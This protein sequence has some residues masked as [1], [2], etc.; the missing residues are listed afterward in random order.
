L[1]FRNTKLL[2]ALLSVSVCTV[3]FVMN[4]CYDI[5]VKLFSGHLLLFSIF[6]VLL[7]Y[8]KLLL[9]FVKGEKTHLN[10]ESFYFE[11]SEKKRL[12]IS[13][14]WFIILTSF[15]IPA[16]GEL[17]KNSV[18]S[19]NLSTIPLYGIY[20]IKTK[21]LNSQIIPLIYNDTLQW[22]QIVIYS[23]NNASVKFLNDSIKNYI[24]DV[25][26]TKKKIGF[27]LLKDTIKY[28]DYTKIANAF[29]LTESKKGDTILQQFIRIDEAD[30]L[31]NSRGFHWINET[32]FNK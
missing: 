31:L 29:T 5:P 18:N 6:L 9:F 4:L 11:S 2:G 22:K 17:N 26:T 30:F 1:F 32:P 19:A 28:F 14:K 24:I 8:K 20:N 21:I 25:D 16:Y 13:I 23:R 12:Y 27:Q 3:I 10:I 7:D 15:F